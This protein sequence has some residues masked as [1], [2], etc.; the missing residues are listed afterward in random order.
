[1]K[2]PGRGFIPRGDHVII[3]LIMKAGDFFYEPFTPHYRR[4]FLVDRVLFEGRTHFQDVQCFVNP[5]FGKMLFLDGKIQ[6]A[7]LDEPVYHESLVHPG[8]VASPDPRRVLILG[9]GEGATLRE[10]L[11]HDSVERAVMVDIDEEL[12]GM[13]RKHLPE[14]SMGAF[15]DSRTE[16][17]YGD[18]RT[19]VETTDQVFDVII[20]DLTEPVEDGPSM[21]LFTAEFFEQVSRR[22]APQ[23]LFVVQ[24]GSADNSYHRF[25]SSVTVTLGAVFPIV[26]PY[27]TFIFSFGLPW[28][29]A[30]ASQSLDPMELDEEAVRKK[31]EERTVRGMNHYQ[32]GLHRGLFA[33]P[34]Y[35]E[36]GI[37]NGRVL[38]D[39]DPFVWKA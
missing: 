4:G 24:A 30:M 14:W 8:L 28:G 32:P 38:R 17:V 31:L 37:R 15:E 36:K 19:F 34:F 13:C 23:G 39:S 12:V 21:K 27:W 9:G 10:I 26:R 33:L 35:L 20:A 16:V 25:F 2:V 1:M 11:K 3:H 5:L 7:Q 29:F 22:L 6:S 18:A